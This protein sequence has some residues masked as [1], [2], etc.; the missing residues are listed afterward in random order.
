MLGNPSEL[1]NSMKV[2]QAGNV[3]NLKQMKN[4]VVV[5]VVVAAA[6]VAVVIVV[7]VV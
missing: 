2:E 4:I 3:K 1:T 6:A 5:V 7:V